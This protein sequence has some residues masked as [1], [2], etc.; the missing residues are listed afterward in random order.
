MLYVS[1]LTVVVS[2]L[3]VFASPIVAAPIPPVLNECS[4][5]ASSRPFSSFLQGATKLLSPSSPSSSETHLAEPPSHA[6]RQRSLP[7]NAS[8]TADDHPLSDAAS[9]ALV[10]CESPPSSFLADGMVPVEL[11]QGA[12]NFPPG[13]CPETFSYLLTMPQRAMRHQSQS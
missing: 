5:Y 1:P 6:S 7:T 13:S 8:E 2:L 12:P 3:A 9:S 10:G 11:A 4:E